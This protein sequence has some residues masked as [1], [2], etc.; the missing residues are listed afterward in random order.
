M[1]IGLPDQHPEFLHCGRDKVRRSD[2]VLWYPNVLH[3]VS[4]C[5]RPTLVPFV[6]FHL[7]GAFTVQ[8]QSACVPSSFVISEGTMLNDS[9]TGGDLEAVFTGRASISALP[10]WPVGHPFAL[11]DELMVLSLEDCENGLPL[12][13]KIQ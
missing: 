10:T 13:M 4:R 12:W 1:L 3:V 9:A 8:V 11:R 6:W 7:A 2:Y 5:I